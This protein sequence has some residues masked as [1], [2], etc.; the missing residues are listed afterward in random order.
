MNIRTTININIYALQRI[1]QVAAASGISRNYIIS[2]LLQRLIVDYQRLGKPWSR[3]R[4][5]DR[6]TKENWRRAH[7]ALRKDEYEFALDLRKVFKCSLSRLI[8]L[9]EYRYLKDLTKKIIKNM[10]NYRYKNYIF[11]RVIVDG[12]IC[13]MFFWGMPRARVMQNLNDSLLS[14]T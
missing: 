4:Y 11:S 14:I 10:D 9:A 3:V 13:W 8:A 12:V 1:S 7:L 2:C 5:Q 6:D